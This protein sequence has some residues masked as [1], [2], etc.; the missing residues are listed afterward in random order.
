MISGL[1]LEVAGPAPMPSQLTD[2]RCNARHVFRR[3]AE[4]PTLGEALRIGRE[5]L[6]E[7]AVAAERLEHMLPRADGAWIAQLGGAAGAEGVDG[8]GDQPVGGIIAAADDVPG[9]RGRDS[10]GPI[11]EEAV[12][13]ALGDQLG[14]G[15]AV[16]IGIMAAEAIVFDI[17]RRAPVIRVAL[18]GR[19]RDDREQALD[20]PRGL[21]QVRGSDDVGADGLERID[22]RLPNKRLCG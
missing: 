2:S 12:A 20:T 7:E 10:D 16:R 8:V 17:A 3:G 1:W 11:R 13:E 6:S 5:L 4:V 22:V 19:H 9:A 21:E 15:L 14:A 18:V